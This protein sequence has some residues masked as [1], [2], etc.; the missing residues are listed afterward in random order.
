MATM[1]D[2]SPCRGTR[3]TFVPESLLVQLKSRLEKSQA[4]VTRLTAAIRFLENN[5]DAVALMETVR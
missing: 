2:E 1:Y 3:G 5:P 4:D